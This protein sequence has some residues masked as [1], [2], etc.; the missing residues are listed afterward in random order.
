MG[1][2]LHER[3]LGPHGARVGVRVD[4]AAL[5]VAARGREGRRD[6][7]QGRRRQHGT[8]GGCGEESETTR[9]APD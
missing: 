2:L 8:S 4:D 9:H 3:D 6:A 7:R 5:F 1:R